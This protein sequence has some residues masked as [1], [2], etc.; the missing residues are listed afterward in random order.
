M[1]ELDPI[2]SIPADPLQRLNHTSDLR[3]LLREY[4][5]LY[6]RLPTGGSTRIRK[7]QRDVREAIS[8][9]IKANPPIVLRPP[10]RLPV[11]DHFRRALDL[12]SLNHMAPVIHALDAVQH[13]LCWEYGYEK[14]PKG[15][16]RKYGYAEIA[17]PKGP[18]QTTELTL[19]IV[20]FA[21]GCTYPAH[22]HADITESYV[23]LS[24]SVSENHQGVYTPGSLIYNPP[25]Q[26]HRITVSDVDPALLAYAW[27]AAPDILVANTMK[28]GAGRRSKPV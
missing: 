5:D 18:I 28:L 27:I 21:P 8:R 16:A 19:G 12:G 22:S 24:G 6:R 2:A 13:M 25:D 4:Y 26:V 11:S 23:C 15:L 9:V 3:Y 20:L 17:G 7:H 10:E 14:V 1:G